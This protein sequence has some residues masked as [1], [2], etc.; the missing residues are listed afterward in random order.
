MSPATV[1][2]GTAMM[3]PGVMDP[4]TAK[5]LVDYLATLKD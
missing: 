2:P 4:V 1:V 3:Y 5:A